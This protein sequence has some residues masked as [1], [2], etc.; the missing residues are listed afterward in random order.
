[1]PGL[2]RLCPPVFEN[3]W[4][5]LHV[6]TAL[7]GMIERERIPQTMLFAGLSG[8]GKATLARRF[9]A[10]VLGA[11][12]KIEHDALSLPKTSSAITARE[13]LPAD[14]RNDDPLVFA[15]HP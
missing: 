4:G 7:R 5:N 6:Q 15:S 14:K 13:K 8:L 10:L 2:K 11:A 1:M 9:A 3:Y 12:D